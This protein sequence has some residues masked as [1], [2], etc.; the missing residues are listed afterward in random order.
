MVASI[1]R[2]WRIGA[3]PLKRFDITEDL[4]VQRILSIEDS[5]EDWSY[6]AYDFE[7]LGGTGTHCCTSSKCI[8]QLHSDRRPYCL[9]FHCLIIYFA[10]LSYFLQ[11]RRA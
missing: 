7:K 11:Q 5:K 9:A 6:H 4:F 10:A 3:A 1:Q 2:H 8:Y